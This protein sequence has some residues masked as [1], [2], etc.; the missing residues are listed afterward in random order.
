MKEST[1]CGHPYK[2]DNDTKCYIDYRQGSYKKT[3]WFHSI[4]LWT[5][6]MYFL[7]ICTMFFIISLARKRSWPFTEFFT[8]LTV[9]CYVIYREALYRYIYYG[10]GIQSCHLISKAKESDV[11]L[12]NSSRKLNKG[13]MFFSIEFGFKLT[14]L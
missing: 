14:W 3:C 8:L 10:S 4:L 12:I 1:I 7:N 11:P 9:H 13:S 2:G 5:M 6:Q